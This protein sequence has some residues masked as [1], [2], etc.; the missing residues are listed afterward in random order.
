MLRRKIR[1]TVL[2]LLLVGG[3]FAQDIYV[4]PIPQKLEITKDGRITVKDGFRIKDVKGKFTDVLSKIKHNNKG[5]RL[6]IDFG[7]KVA[8]KYNL[9]QSSG[10]YMI[11]SSDKEI[12]ITGYDERG[13]FY[14]LQTLMQLEKEGQIPYV[15]ITDFPDMPYRG[16]VEGFYGTPWAHNTRVSLLD[17]Y[18]KFKMNTYL[19][20]P[21]DDPYHSCPNWRLPYPAKEAQNIKELVEAAKRNRVDFV[22]AIH[23]GQDI[24]WTEE[25]YQNLLNKFEAM[26]RLGVRSFALFFDDISGQG[27]DP[28]KQS[29]LLNRLYNEFV[30]TKA[31]V[32]PLIMCPTH[33]TKLWA[34]PA[35]DGYLSVL[36]KTLDPSIHIMWT[37]DYVCGDITPETLEWVSSRIKRPSFIWWNYPVT[38]YVRHII[39]QG[40]VYGL[41]QTATIKNMA[42]FVSNPMEFGEA[43]KLALY[44]VA[45]Y[46]WNIKN[47]NPSEN[48]EH[49]LA[50]LMP[51]A[52]EAYR[53]FAIHSCDTETGYRRDESWET[54]IFTLDK[55]TD[56]QYNKLMDEF[57]KIE[58]APALIEANCEN[59]AL[60]DE[61]RPW[62]VEF[63]K[64][65][66]RGEK[67]LKMAKMLENK[68]LASFWDCYNEFSMTPDDISAY[69]KHKIGT[70]KLQYFIETGM[71][72]LANKYYSELSGQPLP[73]IK[74]IGTFNS[75]TT[76]QPKQML[77]SNITTYYTSS[78]SQKA[79]SW[80]GVDLGELTNVNTVIIRQG[81]NTPN[82]VDFFDSARLEYSLDAKE[83]KTLKDSIV[84][85]Y[86][87]VYEGAPV[88]AR[89]VRLLRLDNSKRV[90]WIAV[91]SFDVNPVKRTAN[92]YSNVSRFVNNSVNTIDGKVVASP[93][94]EVVNIQ[95]GEYIGIELPYATTI[96]NIK[97]DLGNKILKAEY[98]LNGKEWKYAADSARFVR[99][100]NN[101]KEELPVKIN[102]LEL[103]FTTSSGEVLSKIFDKNL[104]TNYTVKSSVDIA[105]PEG[106]K[107][108]TI[109]F[110]NTGKQSSAILKQL[111]ADG[112]TLSSKDMTGS[113]CQFDVAEKT[114]NIVI[115]G[116]LDIYEVVYKK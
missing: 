76:T 43:S 72:E 65:G 69:N 73:T 52:K 99:F 32:N 18:G 30:K 71:D 51:K 93:V 29:E 85:E 77:D 112:K 90:N 27:T 7:A 63:K 2:C 47:Y 45:D 114:T 38:D 116:S 78:D 1:V 21:K 79:G 66:I 98:S 102:K 56:K 67:T 96:S 80:L 94:L 60:L 92:F 35:P 14:G 89:Y 40:P 6:T 8:Q 70:L 95:P 16:V 48:W 58:Q 59:S 61:L 34:D 31:D 5:V 83:W 19:Y 88:E 39:L 107:T 75:L 46:T 49:G 106:V 97:A 87:I 36:G 37:G 42:G 10:A 25:D 20:G 110:R 105:I 15:K 91:R 104:Q 62:L 28:M 41:D 64:L 55:Y 74:A 23:P 103:E 4:N 100:N 82:D 111:T 9:P 22:W 54:E 101:T 68:D 13:A 108:C 84:N 86:D 50:E 44:G 53:T 24:Q 113:F 12:I 11:K 81:R 115:E 3:V 33:Y 109:L 26:Y 17:F 57:I